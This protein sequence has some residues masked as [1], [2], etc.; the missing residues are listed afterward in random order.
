MTN[1]Q[2]KAICADIE[3]RRGLKW[4]WAKID[5]DVKRDIRRAWEKILEPESVGPK[6]PKGEQG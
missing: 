3:D 6:Q 5:A 1:K 4:E 2:W